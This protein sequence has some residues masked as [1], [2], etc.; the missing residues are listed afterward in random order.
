MKY[1]VTL[2][3]ST[4]FSDDGTTKEVIREHEF[5]S[6]N[7]DTLLQEG[8]DYWN[9]ITEE[10]DE[11]NPSMIDH[12]IPQNTKAYNISYKVISVKDKNGKIH[13]HDKDEYKKL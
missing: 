12:N 9:K 11:N 13:I 1:V 7:I 6:E 5:E 10:I 3:I 8:D 2:K 4:T